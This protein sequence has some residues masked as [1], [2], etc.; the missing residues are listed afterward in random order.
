MVV[1][2]RMKKHPA[3]SHLD[4]IEVFASE[5]KACDGRLARLSNNVPWREI[6]PVDR[7]GRQRQGQTPARAW[8]TRS[9]DYA[10]Q[11]YPYYVV[12]EKSLID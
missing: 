1:Y 6:A 9:Q 12:V 5:R 4:T 11:L 2:V 8:T 10:M 3:A 7:L